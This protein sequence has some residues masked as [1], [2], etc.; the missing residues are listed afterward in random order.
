MGGAGFFSWFT[1]HRKWEEPGSS[2]GVPYTLLELLSTAAYDA[3]FRICHFQE[4]E[5]R[6]YTF[7][8]ASSPSL[9]SPPFP[10]FSMSSPLPPPSLCLVFSFYLQDNVLEFPSVSVLKALSLFSTRE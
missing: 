2:P 1:L 7:P 10:P 5:L 4:M 9:L 3:L 8:S 6:K